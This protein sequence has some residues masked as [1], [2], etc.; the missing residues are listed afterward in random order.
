MF[1]RVRVIQ[2]KKGGRGE[3]RGWDLP[4]AEK[5]PSRIAQK[6]AYQYGQAGLVTAIRRGDT[7]AMIDEMTMRLLT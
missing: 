1:V 5:G 2:S 7:A 4:S 6:A 3:K